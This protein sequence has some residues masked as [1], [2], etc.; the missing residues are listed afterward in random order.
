[1]N[2][3]LGTKWMLWRHHEKRRRR[4]LFS[5]VVSLCTAF[6]GIMMIAAAVLIYLM[7]HH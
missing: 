4:G 3:Y 2:N 1:M 7:S 5:A 6:S